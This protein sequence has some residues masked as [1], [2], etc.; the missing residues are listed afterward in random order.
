[1][2]FFLRFIDKKYGLLLCLKLLLKVAYLPS[3]PLEGKA[4]RCSANIVRI[5]EEKQAKM[6]STK[7]NLGRAHYFNIINPFSGR[8]GYTDYCYLR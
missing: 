4:M 5:F 8:E 6:R 1:M 2:P 7:Q 3:L